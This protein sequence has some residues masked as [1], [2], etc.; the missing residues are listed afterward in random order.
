MDGEEGNAS[1]PTGARA[2]ESKH[3]RTG[4]VNLDQDV[5][6]GPVWLPCPLEI[7]HRTSDP[8]HL[9]PSRSPD[10]TP[11]WRLAFDPARQL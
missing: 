3:G 11:E 6:S 2:L 10:E 4:A 7:I 9:L 1:G 5:C 8:P